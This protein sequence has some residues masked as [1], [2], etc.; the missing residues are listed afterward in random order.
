MSSSSSSDERSGRAQRCAPRERGSK[1]TAER[2]AAG[3]AELSLAQALQPPQRLLV[4]A[5]SGV[6]LSEA[7]VYK[8]ASLAI[9]RGVCVSS[10][11]V[12]RAGGQRT[13]RYSSS[14]DFCRFSVAR[15]RLCA[16]SVEWPFCLQRRETRRGQQVRR[17]HS[18][19]AQDGKV[20]AC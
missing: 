6:T 15:L 14:S 10:G 18:L 12:T 20:R 17:F 2:E 5:Q 4:A 3:L 9:L 19:A 11:P 16:R 7:A 1:R 8:A 13:R